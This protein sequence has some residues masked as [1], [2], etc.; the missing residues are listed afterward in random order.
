MHVR[1]PRR[2]ERGRWGEGEMGRLPI[3]DSRYPNPEPRTLNPEPR[4]AFT[5]IELII[6]ILV[7]LILMTLTVA[8]VGNMLDSDRVRGASRQIQNYLAGARDRAIYSASRNEGAGPPPLVGVRL[9][10]DPSLI[11]PVTGDHRGFSSMVYIQEVAPISTTL[12]VWL[13]PVSGDWKASQFPPDADG[14]ELADDGPPLDQRSINGVEALINRGLIESYQVNVGDTLLRVFDLKINFEDMNLGETFYVRFS[15]KPAAGGDP[16]DVQNGYL[17]EGTLSKAPDTPQTA[18]A[19]ACQFRL[20]PSPMPSEEPRLLP[21]GVVIDARSSVIGG[22]PTF[23]NSIVSDVTFEHRAR[24]DGSLDIL[25]NP[26]GVVAGPLAS[27]GLL[28]LVVVDLEDL[29]RGFRLVNFYDPDLVDL[30]NK[31][32]AI[33]GNAFL[34]ADDDPANGLTAPVD[35]DA[36]G[37][38]DERLND[39]Q[40]I[41][42]RTQTGSVYS[43]EVNPV[44]ANP[45]AVAGDPDYG[46]LADPFKYAEIGGEA[47]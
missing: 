28:H 10:S 29:E 19:A 30:N 15:E 36:D 38:P 35:S 42:I 37:I 46:R 34:D 40:I 17:F 31:T 23:G 26:Q 14:N 20:L 5:L 12:R 13:D 44:L 41:S 25:F 47:K 21:E 43:S 2:S 6:V 8:V 9:L 3:P 33:T 39:V 1:P 4:S 16:A 24:A 18:L 22:A 7:M 11:D 32:L 27:A 45:A